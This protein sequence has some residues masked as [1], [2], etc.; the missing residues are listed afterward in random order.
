MPLTPKPLRS[1]LPQGFL[2]LDGMFGPE[3]EPLQTGEKQLWALVFI[4]LKLGG[5]GIFG[6]QAQDFMF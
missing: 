4:S 5:L 6:V 2:A 3:S 1:F